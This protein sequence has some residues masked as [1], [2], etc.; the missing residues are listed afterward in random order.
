MGLL[1]DCRSDR[2]LSFYRL[3]GAACAIAS[4][5]G[6]CKPS[7][8]P[9]QLVEIWGRSSIEHSHVYPRACKL[10]VQDS[11]I[12]D[13]RRLSPLEICLRCVCALRRSYCVETVRLPNKS[14][15]CIARERPRPHHPFYTPAR[16]LGWSRIEA[17]RIAC[18]EV[19]ECVLSADIT[20]AK[21]TQTG[22]LL[23]VANQ[24]PTQSGVAQS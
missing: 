16:S 8:L 13:R 4:S 12:A 23:I 7:L 17:V 15:Y 22:D 3:S 6:S 24:P 5:Q 2:P 9:T 18:A 21:R 14:L 20:E 11:K 19:S 1:R 10:I